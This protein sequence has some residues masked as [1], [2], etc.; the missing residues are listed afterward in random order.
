MFAHRFLAFGGEVPRLANHLLPANAARRAS[1][2]K[3]VNGNLEPLWSP[4]AVATLNGVSS[5]LSLFRLRV[6]DNALWLAWDREVHAVRGPIAGD[7]TGRT[8]YT[9][10]GEPRVTNY[11]LASAGGGGDY[12]KQFYALGVPYPRAAPTLAAS[13]TGTTPNITRAYVYRFLTQW[14]EASA[15]SNATSITIQTGQ[16]VDLS[17]LS[18]AP[19]NS[20]DITALTYSGSTVTITTSASHLNRV[21]DEITLAG[22]TTVSNVTGTWPLTAVNES[23][24]TMT[25]VVTGTPAGVYNNATDTADTWSRVAPFNTTGMRKQIFR[26]QVGASGDVEYKLVDEIDA[27]TT[28]Y[29]DTKADSALGSTLDSMEWDMPPT[30]L[31]CLTALPG[32]SLVGVAG[33]ELCFSEPN[34]PHSWPGIYR[35]TMVYE[36]VAIGAFGNTIVV[37]TEG[38]PYIA[39][40]V[41]PA[42]ISLAMAGIDYPCVSSRGAG[43]MDFGF[44]YP[45]HVGLIL[46]GLSGAEVVTRDLYSREDWA[47][48]NPGTLFSAVHDG[49]YYGVYEDEEARTR[50][51]IIDR[52]SGV[53]LTSSDIACDALYADTVE[54]ALY[55]SAGNVVY[56]WDANTGA[57]MV[58]EY[59]TKKMVLP[60]PMTLTAA[61]VEA[62]FTQ[63][64]AERAAAQAA[65]D[66]VLAAN[67]ALLAT[68]A[69]G[70]LNGETLN[71][72][73]EVNGDGV[74]YLPD[75]Y[76][77]S[78]TFQLLVDGEVKYSRVVGPDTGAFGMPSGYRADNFAVRLLGSVVVSAV[79]VAQNKSGLRAA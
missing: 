10:D 38:N 74:S 58:S 53:V 56:R 55:F 54:G 24:K 75:L 14:G 42:T 13:G 48:I 51:F 77:E 40:G 30:N 43:S 44:L 78:L 26:T 34:Y 23:A 31:K 36:G 6:G 59:L 27:A 25:F 1:N 16:G 5:A 12:P 22:V 50:M 20:G 4:L 49:I 19:P 67:A 35:R 17:G 3:L 15:P 33:N 7:T 29:A 32:G 8:Y 39:N 68:D 46:V 60:Y 65:Y 63:S 62:D 18:V 73:F 66:A 45:S 47:G 21:G 37:A 52:T 11:A 72:G 41:D 57:R 70:T 69:G 71:G 76:L 2:V 9:G 79:V 28:T 64:E 61:K